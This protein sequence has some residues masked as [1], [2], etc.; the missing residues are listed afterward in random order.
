MKNKKLLFFLTALLV[1]SCNTTSSE[2]SEKLSSTVSEV[3]SSTDLA[4]SNEE[5]SNNSVIS[6]ENLSNEPTEDFSEI[7]SEPT[8]DFIESETQ[9]PSVEEFVEKEEIELP[10]DIPSMEINKRYFYEHETLTVSV[11]NAKNL[12][13]VGLYPTDKEPSQIT[14]LKYK[15]VS[16]NQTVSFPISD[17]QGTGEYSVYLCHNDGYD[18]FQKE[19]IYIRNNDKTNYGVK[20]ASLYINEKGNI[21]NATISIT[22]SSNKELTYVLH[23]SVDGVRL[24]NY[25]PIKK[26][27]V[28]NSEEFKVELNDGIVMPDLA[29][30]IE[31]EVL[32]GFSVPYYIYI[33]NDSLKRKPSNYLYSFEV[34]SDLHIQ[35][36]FPTHIS[37]LK[38]AL[39]DMS[40]LSSNSSA[41][42]TTGDN[43]NRTTEAEF[44]L[45]NKIIEEN[46]TEYTPNI[47]Y[48]IGNHD[49]MY[50]TNYEVALDLFKKYTKTESVFYS[51]TINNNKFIVLG[52]TS[53]VMEGKMSVFQLEWL[54][55]ELST[56]NKNDSTFIFLH[57]P[58]IDTVSGSLKTQMGQNWYGFVEQSNKI[59]EIINNYPNVLLFSGHTHWTLDSVQ[60]ALYG[61]KEKASFVNCASVGYL[62]NDSD[63]NEPGS[64]GIYV[65]V[66]EDYV[67]IK[68]REFLD[69]K[70]VSSTQL[71]FPKYK[72]DF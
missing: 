64:E 51:K 17:F 1:T 52:S 54:E 71:V 49:Y 28:K 37:H 15:Y 59:K 57:Q 25:T 22:P 62:W 20:N 31:I 30:E 39:R 41:L 8:V 2:E 61:N 10:L 6:S 46:K 5:S 58:L 33:D 44:Q 27:K 9:Q 60:P 23:W 14:S 35:S 66:Y 3:E 29:N 40:S 43:T 70:W 69:R 63:T 36:T 13:W 38:M 55:E 68:G 42:F 16:G 47:Y 19:D 50:L 65:D 18:T 48:T 4:S 56:V 72:N 7:S 67:F 45:L 34:I 21:K 32:E 24:P 12:D 53:K 26:I 11:K